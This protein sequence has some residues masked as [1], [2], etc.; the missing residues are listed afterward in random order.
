M[1]AVFAAFPLPVSGLAGNGCRTSFFGENVPS[2]GRP[3]LV[4]PSGTVSEVGRRQI[5]VLPVPT[6]PEVVFSVET[7]ADMPIHCIGVE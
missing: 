6:K 7:V 1:C 2:T 4:D 5:S 3:S